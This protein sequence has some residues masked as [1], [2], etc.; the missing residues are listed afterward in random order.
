MINFITEKEPDCGFCLACEACKNHF[1][2]SHYAGLGIAKKLSIQHHI[3]LM[4]CLLENR[5]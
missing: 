4:I 1:D 2:E 5:Q 3:M